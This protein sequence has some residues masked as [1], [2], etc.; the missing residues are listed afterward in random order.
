M[1]AYPSVVYWQIL[2]G[3]AGYCISLN[4]AEHCGILLNTAEYCWLLTNIADI[5]KIANIV[6]IIPTLLR[7]PNT[8]EGKASASELE[9]LIKTLKGRYEW[10]SY[11]G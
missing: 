3:I 2:S 1:Q 6:D 5:A 9:L 11:K 7:T 4:V 8:D 10:Y